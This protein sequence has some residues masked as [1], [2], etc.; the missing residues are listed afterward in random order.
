MSFPGHGTRPLR[1]TVI[2]DREDR[3]H[4]EF[5]TEVLADLRNQAIVDTTVTLYPL[6]DRLA[7]PLTQEPAL[8]ELIENGT[9]VLVVNWDAVNGD[10]DF[11]GDVALRWFEHRQVALRRWVKEG[12][13]LIV[14][15]QATQGV[16]DNRY[17]AAVL[18]DGEVRLSGREDPLDPDAERV[19]MRGDARMTR[20]TRK[21]VRFRVLDLIE[22]RYGLRFEQLFPKEHAGRL[23]PNYLRG[24]DTDELLYRGWFKRSFRRGTL[25]WV[26]YARRATWWPT[27]F[28][29]MLTAKCD[30]GAIFVTTMLLSA[31]RQ[32]QLIQAM[33]LT[34]PKIDS[35]PQPGVVRRAFYRYAAQSLAG[36][37]SGLAVW[38][39]ADSPV[40]PFLV[41]ISV[42][43]ILEALP[44]L[45]R[46][47]RRVIR[48]FSGA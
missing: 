4:G 43:V 36:A 29:V 5:W 34:Y 6:A 33:L 31:T 12:G 25:S 3:H 8:L 39:P 40:I 32:V 7:Q 16:P 37:L 10:P 20:I 47:V 48:I 17:Y 30:K 23:V 9:D 2:V 46:G 41:A 13:M 28:P 18:G 1:V 44:S 19:R 21:S 22:P 35:L 26:P 14:E 27:N 11:G 24:M 15:G 45:W 38:N 42:T